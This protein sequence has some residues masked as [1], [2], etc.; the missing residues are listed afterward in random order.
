MTST[1]SE[2]KS[3]REGGEEQTLMR[4]IKVSTEEAKK[5][6]KDRGLEQAIGD[7]KEG[8]RERAERVKEREGERRKMTTYR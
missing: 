2:S 7:M 1:M 3:D 8:G 6:R 5:K 4:N